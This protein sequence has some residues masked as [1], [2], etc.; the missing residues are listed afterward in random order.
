MQAIEPVLAPG[1]LEVHPWPAARG[2]LVDI[3]GQEI[4]FVGATVVDRQGPGDEIGHVVRPRAEVHRLPVEEL[5]EAITGSIRVPEVRAVRDAQRAGV[6]GRVEGLDGASG[7][8]LV[9]LIGRQCGDPVLGV[10]LL[11]VRRRSA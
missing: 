6:V 11:P 5:D 10:V 4:A 8:G 9:A 3:V 2:Q 7:P 1:L